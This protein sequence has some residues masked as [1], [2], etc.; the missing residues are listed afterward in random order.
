MC[1]C[2]RQFY[3]VYIRYMSGY[4][5]PISIFFLSF[6]E[7]R[8]QPKYENIFQIC[9]CTICVLRRYSFD[10]YR[11]MVEKDETRNGIFC[12]RYVNNVYWRPWGMP[13]IHNL[14]RCLVILNGIYW[15][16]SVLLTSIVFCVV[17]C[18]C[19]CSYMFKHHVSFCYSS[20]ARYHTMFM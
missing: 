6:Y 16:L 19:C 11:L 13:K 3:T 9:S 10:E 12:V 18:C 7:N 17:F 8:H 5:K 20:S 15:K 1:F 2:I 14:Y 4:N